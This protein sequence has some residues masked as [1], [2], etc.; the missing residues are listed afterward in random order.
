[1]LKANSLPQNEKVKAYQ[2][3][4]EL[5]RRFIERV[6]KNKHIYWSLKKLTLLI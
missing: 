1:M 6:L 4:H 3:R 5:S 2:L